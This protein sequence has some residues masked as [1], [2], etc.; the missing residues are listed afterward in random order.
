MGKDAK[1]IKGKGKTRAKSV[2]GAKCSAMFSSFL[3]Y[4]L[5]RFSNAADLQQMPS[6]SKAF[7]QTKIL[8]RFRQGSLLSSLGRFFSFCLPTDFFL[9]LMFRS[10]RKE[11]PRGNFCQVHDVN[12]NMQVT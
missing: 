7:G 5:E 12:Q 10:N 1:G 9:H 11:I 3:K 4:L 2:K 8:C 6:L